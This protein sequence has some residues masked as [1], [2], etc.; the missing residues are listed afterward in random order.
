MNSTTEQD[1][2]LKTVNTGDGDTE[3]QTDNVSNKLKDD[4]KSK[5]DERNSQ[6]NYSS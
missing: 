6:G 3:L 2:E 4:D 5:D 1:T